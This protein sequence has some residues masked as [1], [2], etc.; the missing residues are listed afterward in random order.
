MMSRNRGELYSSYFLDIMGDDSLSPFV[1]E[2]SLELI[3]Y[4]LRDKNSGELIHRDPLF[5]ELIDF[6]DHDVSKHE[7][8]VII[9]P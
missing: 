2:V 8:N 6:H 1:Y 3:E 9:H 5:L 7:E 4:E